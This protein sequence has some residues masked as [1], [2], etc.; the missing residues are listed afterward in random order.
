MVAGFLKE[1]LPEP[2]GSQVSAFL[3]TGD[4]PQQAHD[5]LGGLFGGR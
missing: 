3:S 1:K 2:I 5:L 4:L